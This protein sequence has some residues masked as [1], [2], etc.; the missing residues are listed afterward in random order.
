MAREHLLGHYIDGWEQEELCFG[1][2]RQSTGARRKTAIVYD[3]TKPRSGER[4][5]HGNASFA[6]HYLSRAVREAKKRGVG[7]AFLH[8]HPVCGWQDMSRDDI[9]AERDV[10]SY[11]ARVTKHPLVGLTVGR[12]GYWS[13]RWWE[14]AGR[15]VKL[16]WC[17]KVRVVGS[18]KFGIYA[19]P[20]DSRRRQ[21]SARLRRTEDSWGSAFQQTIENLRVGIVGLGSVGS[22]TAEALARIGVGA[23]A[24]ID[25]DRVEE[26]NL[27]RLLY[28]MVENIGKRK[29]D[30]A[31]EAIRK[32]ATNADVVIDCVGR[33]I[34]HDAAYRA[35]LDCDLI[36]S[37]VDRPIGRDVLNYVAQA[38]LVPV[39][40][41]G[42]AVEAYRHPRKFFS[43]HWRAHVVTPEHQCLRCAGQYSSGDVVAELD[44]S[45]TDPVYISGLEESGVRQNMN[46]FPF[47]L[48]AA[49]LQTNLALRYMLG[50]G[51]W[52]PISRQE[53]QFTKGIVSRE[54]RRCG[55]G[56][57]FRGKVAS[58]DVSNPPYLLASEAAAADTRSWWARWREA[59]RE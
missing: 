6:S 1:F 23:F 36:L 57:S 7:L 31:A 56:C 24:L 40:D 20:G 11:P 5:L 53:Y 15:E 55:E 16:S 46:T 37:C 42:V 8:S 13:A 17:A 38:H 25:G 18:K 2:W 43:A 9:V 22:I 51:W 12:D 30:V 14:R 33:E 59:C 49:S 44:G 21:W 45:L 34:Q 29:V 52:P 19:R 32:H 28:G 39:I 54:D 10:I 47:A 58:G 3:I 48:G 26:H 50:H 41:A 35:A 27:D 4:S